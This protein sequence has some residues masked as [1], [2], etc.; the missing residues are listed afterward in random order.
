MTVPNDKR[1]VTFMRLSG[2]TYF[3]RANCIGRKERVRFAMGKG[4]IM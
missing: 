3:V 1:L 2:S 4:K